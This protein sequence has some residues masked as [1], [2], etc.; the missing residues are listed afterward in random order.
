[1]RQATGSLITIKSRIA[2]LRMLPKISSEI[3]VFK[4]GYPSY[5]HYLRE[6]P[7]LYFEA[8]RGPRAKKKKKFGEHQS[9]LWNTIAI[10]YRFFGAPPPKKN[11]YMIALQV[12]ERINLFSF[13]ILNSSTHF[14][15]TW[16]RYLGQ[17][18]HYPHPPSENHPTLRSP[19]NSVQ[20]FPSGWGSSAHR[21]KPVGSYS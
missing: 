8:K 2:M 13:K 6:D 9:T 7:W 16:T 1:M 20:K 18:H 11:R 15:A 10:M 14:A 21:S 19:G 12:V 17:P 5:E 4:F 3:Q